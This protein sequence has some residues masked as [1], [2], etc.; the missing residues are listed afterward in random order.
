MIAPGVS[1]L[2][3]FIVAT[4]AYAASQPNA[5]PEVK[6]DIPKDFA[7]SLSVQHFQKGEDVLHIEWMPTPA[8][9]AMTRYKGYWYPD[10]G[11]AD[12][13]HGWTIDVFQTQSPKVAAAYEHA[14]NGYA[15][16][17]DEAMDFLTIPH[18]RSL[19]QSPRR[20]LSYLF[21]RFERKSFRWGD[22]VSFFSQS[23][24]D[25]SMPEPANGRL[26][27]EVFGVTRDARFTV[28]A[29][30][31][32]SHPKLPD[33]GQARDMR[34]S[35]LSDDPGFEQAY[36]DAALQKNYQR[37]RRLQEDQ[38]KREAA[39]MSEQPGVKLIE[40]CKLD[41][42]QPSIVALDQMIDSIAIQ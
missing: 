38:E 22:A 41:E 3:L 26:T 1:L 28:I 18:A 29:S 15:A 7:H 10:A 9:A 33:D 30:L 6:L 21:A 24:Q 5:A 19:F 32:A 37:L 4:V 27:Y 25:T 2:L 23:V 14:S 17:L 31:S 20:A 36:Y 34:D 11:R 39:A 13:K 42:F 35:V 8:R 40:T 16:D 12:T